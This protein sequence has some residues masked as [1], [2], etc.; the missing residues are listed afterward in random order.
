MDRKCAIYNRISVENK[1]QLEKI[2]NILIEYCQKA[3]G[4]YAVLHSVVFEYE[5]SPV[6]DKYLAVLKKEN[7]YF[8]KYLNN[9]INLN[10]SF[11]NPIESK[12]NGEILNFLNNAFIWRKIKTKIEEKYKKEN[13]REKTWS[14]RILIKMEM[15]LW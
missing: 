3:L 5:S 4:K 6:I 10:D 11:E 12:I 13:R 9:K 8:E 1:T 7:E 14:I 15:Q 2:R